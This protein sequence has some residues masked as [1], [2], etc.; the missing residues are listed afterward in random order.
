MGRLIQAWATI[1]DP[2]GNPVDHLRER[3]GRTAL[4]IDH[5]DGE[6][7]L[8]LLD[9]MDLEAIFLYEKHPDEFRKLAERDL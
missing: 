8:M 5:T 1:S 4:A 6:R 9:R 2:V 7:G 3:Y